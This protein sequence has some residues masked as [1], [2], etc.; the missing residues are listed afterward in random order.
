MFYN[1]YHD[2][3][4]RMLTWSSSYELLS[5]EGY[6]CINL[7]SVVQC[8]VEPFTYDLSPWTCVVPE[9]G[10]PISSCSDVCVIIVYNIWTGWWNDTSFSG[11]TLNASQLLFLQK[12]GKTASKAKTV[13]IHCRMFYMGQIFSHVKQRFSTTISL[14][15]LTTT[16]KQ[17]I[18]KKWF[19]LICTYFC[20]QSSFGLVMKDSKKASIVIQKTLEASL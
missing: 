14:Y 17:W 16:A 1:K 12:R 8:K 2:H 20:F 19:T 7:S 15:F 18:S 4:V 6:N 13:I 5:L 3:I 9:H 10:G 11:Q